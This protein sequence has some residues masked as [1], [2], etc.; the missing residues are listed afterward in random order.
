[1]SSSLAIAAVSGALRKLLDDS[2]NADPANDPSSDAALTGTTVTVCPLDRA[3]SLAK[4]PQLNLFMYQ[5][6]IN[7]A[8][9]N[10]EE[11]GKSRAGESGFPPLP[12]NLHYFITAYAPEDNEVLAQRVL[13]RAMSVLHDHPVLDSALIRSALKDND[14]ADQVEHIRI[15]PQPLSIDELTKLWGIFQTE[16]RVSAAYLVT[17][18]LIESNRPARAP[19]PVLKRG[20]D[21]AGP[22]VLAS[23][24]PA[25]NSLYGSW[26]LPILPPPGGG[27]STT[28]IIRPVGDPPLARLGETL[29][30]RG[31]GLSPYKT[32][33][34]FNHP[35]L[36]A[37]IELP[38]KAGDS[39]EQLKVTLPSDDTTVNPS[40]LQDWPCGLYRVSLVTERGGIT[41]S[42]NE[43]PF[44]L[45][46]KISLDPLAAA[47]GT[48]NLKVEC[49]PR[50]RPEQE[51]RVY[52]LFGSSQEIPG[53][54]STPTGGGANLKKPTTLTFHMKPGP[55]DVGVHTVRLR[56]D[57]VDSLPLAVMAASGKLG[58][59]SNQQVTIT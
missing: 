59:D 38:V 18:V 33:A 53:T 14:L 22:V 6:E 27:G 26:V 20:L 56:V 58:F 57:G 12:L 39:G 31:Q 25:L 40:V 17:V 2:I 29:V 50:I 11:P 7:N 1:M 15:S 32:M 44:M 28:K 24:G 48:L 34:R 37:P 36:A 46:P 55:A 41:I 10:L 49:R 8:W 45:A 9:R 3:R 43:I 35:L 30:L 19:L 51:S 21:D 16:Y 54:I 13:G 42:T 47:H 5:T 4:G 52:L 23:L